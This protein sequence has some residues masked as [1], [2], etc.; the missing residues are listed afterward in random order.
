MPK[1][2][3]IPGIGNVEFPDDMSDS[4]IAKQAQIA[5]QSANQPKPSR[6]DSLK[7]GPANMPDD[8][9]N[10]AREGFWK[11][12]GKAVTA[13]FNFA[14]NL[15]TVTPKDILEGAGNTIV[16]AGSGNLLGA[17]G[18]VAGGALV[19][20]VLKGPS[21]APEARAATRTAIMER[22]GVPDEV[23]P[24]TPTTPAG[25]G[26]ISNVRSLFDIYKKVKK[27]SPTA[28]GEAGF[29]KFLDFVEGQ[30][31][32]PTAPK[33]PSIP[34]GVSEPLPVASSPVSPQSVS[35][36]LPANGVSGTAK[37]PQTGMNG[38]RGVLESKGV[39][40][41]RTVGDVSVQGELLSPASS[42]SVSQK[43]VAGP[44][45]SE[46]AADVRSDT[47]GSSSKRVNSQS[48]NQAADL[49]AASI[50]PTRIKGLSQAIKDGLAMTDKLA[51][52]GFTPDEAKSMNPSSWAKL[53]H[54]SGVPAPTTLAAKSRVIFELQKK[55]AGPA[56]SVDE[57][58]AVFKK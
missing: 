49:G 51:E 53:A 22:M 14:A 20:S 8:S 43:T 52:W 9:D 3:A 28:L 42:A 48:G 21:K 40:T 54:D 10:P 37:L 11:S 47:A 13:P 23:K 6:K 12:L 27:L 58:L 15:D 44:E 36:G 24:A 41:S 19:G 1:V 45:I 30:Q 33:P 57:M 31:E 17:A 29:E 5:H 7:G 55:L 25:G 18:D 34:S 2:V 56:R 38:S 35:S 39:R 32:N 50:Q 4:D 46:T 26:L 16:K